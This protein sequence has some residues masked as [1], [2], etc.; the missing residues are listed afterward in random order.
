MVVVT[1]GSGL[2]GSHVIAALVA[3]GERVRAIARA[4]ARA[5]VERLGAEAVVGD[6][7]DPAAW[8]AACGGPDGI[9]AIVHAAALVAQPVALDRFL[10]VNVGGTEAAIAAARATRARLVHISSVAV[11]G[12]RAA[13]TAGAGTVGEDYPHQPLPPHEFY[14]RSKRLAEARLWEAT[15]R[16]GLW[17]VAL[18]PN[19]VFGEHDRLFSPR[20]VRLVRAGMVPRIGHGGNRLSLVYAGS[21][22]AAVTAA[23]DADVPTGRAYNVT[24]EAGL[25]Q[26]GLV[27]AIASALG[28]PVTSIRVPRAPAALALGAFLRL[29]RAWRPGR[30]AG[31]SGAVD[32]LGAENP[33]RSDR[34]R[35]ELGWR[36]TIDPRTAIQ[37]TVRWVLE[38]GTPGR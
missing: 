21:V 33:Y 37:R 38:N 24:D 26:R 16:G 10:A 34:A 30:Y 22:A 29:R 1:G 5:S 31:A 4:P 9:Q 2:V 35:S 8:D 19:V 20:V 36:P 17:A 28:T 3:R 18:R 25:T 12:R 13:Y 15:A 6:V 11:Y 32:F 7:T 23:I 27:D 14:A